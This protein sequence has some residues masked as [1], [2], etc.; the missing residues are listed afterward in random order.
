MSKISATLARYHDRLNNL[1][2]PMS[3]SKMMAMTVQGKTNPIH[4]PILALK[5]RKI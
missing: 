4:N 3:K 5:V 2:Q 1:R